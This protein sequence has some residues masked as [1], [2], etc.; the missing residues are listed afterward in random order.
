MKEPIL[1]CF[2]PAVDNLLRKNPI[3]EFDN[4]TI[5]M[6]RIAHQR[7]TRLFG[8]KFHT[9]QKIAE[10]RL[11]LYVATLVGNGTPLIL[12]MTPEGSDQ[13]IH[14]IRSEQPIGS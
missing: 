11:S 5:K 1:L 4:I 2:Y 8:L 10:S 9:A 12:D 7:D 6:K 13:Q 14:L 3:I